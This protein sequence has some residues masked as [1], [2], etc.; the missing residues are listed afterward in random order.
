MTVNAVGQNDNS[1]LYTVIK[2]TAIGT[3]AG[4]SLKYFWPVTTQEDNVNKRTMLNYW[5]KITN[6]NKAAEI[7]ASGITSP[8]KDMFLSMVDSKEKGIFSMSDIHKRVIQLGG[9]KSAD[10]KEF[11]EIIRNV[12]EVSKKITR[13]FARAHKINL[14]LKRPPIPFIIAG[15]G[16]GFFSG[17]I[18]NIMNS[19]V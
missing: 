17:F 16:V 19:D 5:R 18:H 7:K 6:R 4:Y 15:A 2:S 14:K 12:D 13:H 11:R 10:G 1:R 8:A 9:K 3:V